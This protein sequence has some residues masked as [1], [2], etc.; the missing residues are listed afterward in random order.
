MSSHLHGGMVAARG[1]DLRPVQV[2][3]ELF[4][5]KDESIN[6]KK[7]VNEQDDRTK[8]LITKVQKLSEDL[9]KAKDSSHGHHGGVD[10]PFINRKE[11]AEVDDMVADLR[12]Q[13]RNVS[14]ENSQLKTKMN[15]FK[16]LHESESRKGA[17][18]DHIPPRVNSNARKLQPALTVRGRGRGRG[19]EAPAHVPQ[20]YD[21]QSEEIAKLEEIITTL[22][23][24]LNDSEKKNDVLEEEVERLRLHQESQEQQADMERLAMQREL[25]DS[26]AKLNQQKN[27][28]DALSEKH[29]GLQEAH[30]DAVKSL[31]NLNEDL[32]E[33]RR[34]RSALEDK[35]KDMVNS[36]KREEELNIIIEDLKAEKRLLEE[37]Q[38]RLL[39]MRFSFDREDEFE[40]ERAVLRKRVA[41]LQNELAEALREKSLVHG[42]LQTAHGDVRVLTQDKITAEGNMYNL[43]HELELLRDKLQKI[44]RNGLLELHQIEEAITLWQLRH[45]KPQTADFIGQADHVVEDFAEDK[46]VLQDLRLQYAKCIEELEKTR[47]LL[48]MQERIS[49]DYK[50]EVANL[51]MTLQ[52]TKN[53]YELRLEEDSR[54]LDLRAN[55]IA[56]LESQLKNIAYGTA[57][58]PAPIEKTIDLAEDDVLLEKGQNLITLHLDAAFI[59]E[60]GFKFLRRQGLDDRDGDAFTSMIYFDF[61]DFE[62]QVTPVGV[63]LAPYYNMTSRQK[64][65]V[66]DF[67]LLYL[68]SKSLVLHMCRT[69]GT[70]FVE[71][72]TC[73]VVF[74]DIIDPHRTSKLQ[75]VGQLISTHDGTTVIGSLKYSLSVKIPMV[76]AIRR[77]KERTTAL[78]LL[79]VG[80]SQSAGRRF[81]PRASINELAV[82]IGE[83]SGLTAPAGKNPAV[84][85]SFQFYNYDLVVTVGFDFLESAALCPLKLFMLF[86]RIQY[87]GRVIPISISTNHI[88]C[89]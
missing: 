47:K 19:R 33:E 56:H 62:T 77:F 21:D 64:V 87:T 66:D 5:L 27:T 49:K 53:E 23:G 67:F 10:K 16:S 70:D 17:R 26:R 45:K 32:K 3:D 28:L 68:Q 85:L 1:R 7:K 29:R 6:L 43:R 48:M 89:R 42:Q 74:K 46:K 38:S 41:D 8:Q 71:F 52:A 36:G 22:R 82:R 24:R 72:A 88:P 44:T 86:C 11:M 34:K 37:E 60:D 50:R 30:E 40:T 12:D 76:Q 55:R 81:A 51:G 75:Y 9:R 57:K 13:L 2:S 14:K 58:V 65:Y 20:E 54:L 25:S 84:Y 35:L 63:G 73:L 61:F 15:F 80:N 79:S 31:E 69:D 18:Y 4:G 78:N 39:K 83:V 59:G